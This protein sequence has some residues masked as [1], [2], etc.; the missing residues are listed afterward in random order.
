MTMKLHLASQPQLIIEHNNSSDDD[1]EKK[2]CSCSSSSSSGRLYNSGENSGIRLYNSVPNLPYPTPND[3]PSNLQLFDSPSDENDNINSVGEEVDLDP[4]DSR[5]IQSCDEPKGVVRSRIGDKVGPLLTARPKSVGDDT[6]R[7]GDL[8]ALSELVPGIVGELK[9]KREMIAAAERGDMLGEEEEVIKGVKD[10]VGRGNKEDF[11]MDEYQPN[12]RNLESMVAMSSMVKDPGCDN[13]G[14][15][16]ADENVTDGM[17]SGSSDSSYEEHEREQEREETAVVKEQEGINTIE[18][19]LEDTSSSCSSSTVAR[20]NSTVGYHPAEHDIDRI[21]QS[22][23]NDPNPALPAPSPALSSHTSLPDVRCSTVDKR[24]VEEDTD[25][26][27]QIPM[28]LP[29]FRPAT[30]CTNASDFIVRCFIAR[31]RC[32]IT[33]TKHGRSR[34]CKSRQRILHIHSDGKCLSW[35]PAKGEPT[36]SKRPPRLDLTTCIEVRHVRTKDPLNPMVT[37]TE[38]LRQKCEAA[39][40][41]KSFSLIFGNRTVDITAVTEDQ[42]NIMMEGFSALCYRLQLANSTASDSTSS[43]HYD[44]VS[45]ITISTVSGTTSSGMLKKMKK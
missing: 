1:D 42:C 38:I 36:S 31:L 12:I 11:P 5:K 41:S 4:I 44:T 18:A 35:K 39:D 6:E 32:G 27:I 2:S 29:N 28:C 43:S 14:L 37:S 34:W 8:E 23:P 13:G 25:H 17:S 40:V 30:G 19:I 20:T 16:S 22:L 9:I 33:V 24:H 45:D 3:D 21:D 26:A 10:N 7:V 15:D